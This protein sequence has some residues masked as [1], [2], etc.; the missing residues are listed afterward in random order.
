M[1]DQETKERFVELRAEGLSYQKIARELNVGKQ[2]LINWSKQLS[3][4]IENLR[5]ISLEALQERYCVVAR[6]RIELLGDKIQALHD[7]LQYRNLEDIPTSKLFELLLKYA[8][9]L[10]EEEMATRFSA[11]SNMTLD[12]EV[13]N[14]FEPKTVDTWLA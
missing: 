10:K 11:E 4:D 14:L 9:S 12:E 5:A 2:P 7:E 6:R 8:K 1:K 3:H 13:S